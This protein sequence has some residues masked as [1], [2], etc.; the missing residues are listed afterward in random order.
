MTETQATAEPHAPGEDTQPLFTAVEVEEFGADDVTAGKAIGQM[1]SLLFLYTVIA[2]SLVSWWTYRTVS[3]S[4]PGPQPAE[5]A[6][7]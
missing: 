1:L 7:E 6:P 3:A 2:M 5:A 4:S